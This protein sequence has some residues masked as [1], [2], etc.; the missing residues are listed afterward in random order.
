MLN[1]KD[2]ENLFDAELIQAASTTS[3]FA[4]VTPEQKLRL[5]EPKKI[6]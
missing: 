4:R 6:S 3:V 2:L 5:V 1:G